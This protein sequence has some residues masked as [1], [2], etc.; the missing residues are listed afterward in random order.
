MQG[1]SEMS[2]RDNPAMA[3]A[4]SDLSLDLAAQARPAA[5]PAISRLE[6][7]PGWITYG[8]IVV[9][10]IALGLW[11]RDLSLPTAAN[12]RITTGGL[13]GERK[14]SILDQ[15]EAGA[16]GWIAPYS[17]DRHGC[18]RSGTRRNGVGQRRIWCCRS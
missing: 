14:S 9:T 6:F 16:R 18:R 12:P 2:R 5:A 7:L 1:G 15:A 17:G 4:M 10:W 11:Y 13:C 3:A 8:P